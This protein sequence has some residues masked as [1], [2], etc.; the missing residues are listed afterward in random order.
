MYINYDEH[1][2]Q[3]FEWIDEGLESDIP[4]FKGLAELTEQLLKDNHQMYFDLHVVD[5]TELE[6][7]YAMIDNLK[8][9]IKELESKLKEETN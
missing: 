4:A 2:Y 6:S 5:K 8:E 3:A 1:D 7:N 9:K